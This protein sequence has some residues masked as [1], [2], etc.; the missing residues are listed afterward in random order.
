MLTERLAEALKCFQDTLF[1]MP[2]FEMADDLAKLPLKFQEIAC[3]SSSYESVWSYSCLIKQSYFEYIAEHSWKVL[4]LRHENSE[5][6]V[7][8][9]SQTARIELRDFSLETQIKLLANVVTAFRSI[10]SILKISSPV[11]N[12]KIGVAKTHRVW[13]GAFPDENLFRSVCASDIKVAEHW[14]KSCKGVPEI[15]HVL[16]TSNIQ[17]LNGS[18]DHI[19][20]FSNLKIRSIDYLLEEAYSQF[21]EGRHLFVFA[22][23]L[24]LQKE[25]AEACDIIRAIIL[26]LYGGFYID[27]SVQ[28]VPPVV[29]ASKPI[30][31]EELA[32]NL[33]PFSPIA[34]SVYLPFIC[35]P[36][37]RQMNMD[38]KRMANGFEDMLQDFSSRNAQLFPFLE[39]T[40]MYV[41]ERKSDFSARQLDFM[42][43]A[44]YSS[45][46]YRTNGVVANH[47]REIMGMSYNGDLPDFHLTFDIYPLHFAL[48]NTLRVDVSKESSGAMRTSYSGLG[49]EMDRCMPLEFH[50]NA[51]GSNSSAYHFYIKQGLFKK[52][53]NSWA[54]KDMVKNF[55]SIE[56]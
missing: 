3:L 39:N 48:W 14:K 17:L 52:I 50:L 10:C 1:G 2:E 54:K 23:A 13:L 56:W 47:R 34:S 55:R 29:F 5:L 45:E 36:Y 24:I 16:W 30:E 15:E 42:L 27:F 20:K 8:D 49:F 9:L 26:Y 41:G 11:P 7:C 46:L 37:L 35:S 51:S 40:M 19:A 44:I 33:E 31:T 22:R 43:Q 6:C 12:T 4:L 21:P 38:P 32:I 28:Q 53:N 18:Y 25:Y